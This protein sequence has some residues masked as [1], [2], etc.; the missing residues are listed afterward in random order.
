MKSTWAYI[1]LY[2]PTV[3]ACSWH[4]P[5]S[6]LN[7]KGPPQRTQKEEQISPP[8]LASFPPSRTALDE[9][10]FEWLT[11]SSFIIPYI[12]KHL[13]NHTSILGSIGADGMIRLLLIDFGCGSS[14]LANEVRSL[15]ISDNI[16]CKI[17]LLDENMS[18][19]WGLS[20]VMKTKEWSD[21]ILPIRSVQLV[22]SLLSSLLGS[23]PSRPDQALFK[24]IQN[25]QRSYIVTWWN[26]FQPRVQLSR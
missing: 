12:V 14:S 11:N 1:S 26:R 10:C 25:I 5:V 13:Q 8:N 19:R 4:I 6:T 16:S 17:L 21:S 20:E 2:K 23:S 15:I 3:H 22:A 9:G 24:M 7:R 18:A